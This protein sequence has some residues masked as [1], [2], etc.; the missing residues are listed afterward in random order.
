VLHD[1]GMGGPSQYFTLPWDLI[2]VLTSA[3]LGSQSVQLRVLGHWSPGIPRGRME[4]GYVFTEH[5]AMLLDHRICI[6]SKFSGC[7]LMV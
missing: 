1:P 7:I 3:H 4:E 5:T 2:Q 6:L